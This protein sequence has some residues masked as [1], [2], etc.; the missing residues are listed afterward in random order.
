MKQTPNN[1]RGAKGPVRVLIVDDS[2]VTREYL[3]DAFEQAP[4][5]EVA[6]TVSNGAEALKFLDRQRP[7]IVLMDVNM[8]VMDGLEATRRIMSTMP[9]PVVMMSATAP[10]Q[11]E[12]SFESMKAG[13][14]A[15]LQKPPGP[16]HPDQSRAIRRLLTTVRALSEVKL[17][18][19][20]ENLFTDS[21]QATVPV[22]SRLPLCHSR[23]VVVGA[24]TGG[25]PVINTLL[26]AL[27]ADFPYPV[28]LVQHISEGFV[29]GFVDWL[30]KDSGIPVR[31]AA[32]GIPLSGGTAYVAPD[33]AHLTV[34]GMETIVLAPGTKEPHC[35]SV[36]KLFESAA[37]TYGARTVAILLTGMGADG[38][39]E[40]KALRETGAITIA[41]SK[42][43]CVVFGMP[44]EAIRMDAAQHVLNP[45]EIAVFLGKLAKD[46]RK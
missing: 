15:S 31:L 44:G 10:D 23:L 5:F 32:N 2:A 8:P 21:R 30:G 41:Q 36:A 34:S 45:S 38:A 22:R 20:R 19:R 7:D 35:P 9:L 3:R 37:A 14:L 27:P 33:N 13:A 26:A 17:V 24:S 28:L 1:E 4:G 40:L 29:D 43:S 16:N 46:E 39:A 6:G 12:L 42:D 18:R 11:V 25:P